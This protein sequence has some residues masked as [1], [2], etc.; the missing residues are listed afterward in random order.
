M[1]AEFI[2]V[3]LSFR[4]QM[5]GI[6]IGLIYYG[7]FALRIYFPMIITPSYFPL[8]VNHKVSEYTYIRSRSRLPVEDSIISKQG[9]SIAFCQYRCCAASR[10]HHIG[11]IL[12]PVVCSHTTITSPIQTY[13]VWFT[14]GKRHHPSSS[15]QCAW[16]TYLSIYW[17]PGLAGAGCSPS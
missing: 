8:S 1:N 11:R 3:D 17:K 10:I 5:S 12:V 15:S 13:G 7:Y 14:N 2:R 6:E 9:R 4:S 16:V